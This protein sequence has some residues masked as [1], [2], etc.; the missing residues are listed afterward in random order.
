MSRNRVKNSQTLHWSTIVKWGALV[1]V[2]A[3]L[4]LSYLVFKNQIVSTASETAKQEKQLR[5]IVERNRQLSVD[6]A[7]LKS[8]QRLERYV[9]L[10]NSRLPAPQQFVRIT[11]ERLVRLDRTA[12]G[13]RVA[14]AGT[15]T[16]LASP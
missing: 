16:A 9:A 3:L 2:F 4:G 8:P 15:E 13:M 1:G 14:R 11:E 7:R 10:V 12:G 6:V 5:Q